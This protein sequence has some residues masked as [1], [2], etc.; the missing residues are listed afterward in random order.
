MITDDIETQEK[1]TELLNFLADY[2]P[3]YSTG[4]DGSKPCIA[5]KNAT[6]KELR[7]FLEDEFTAV[8]DA[9]HDH[10]W[11]YADQNE[12]ETLKQNVWQL[13]HNELYVFSVFLEERWIGTMLLNEPLTRTDVRR[14][15]KNFLKAD[16]NWGRQAKKVGAEARIVYWDETK[17]RTEAFTPNEYGFT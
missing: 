2:H 7:I 1:L 5:L 16:K 4:P 11:V 3:K 10:Y 14:Q 17:N 8:Y 6:G 12:F 9:W 15:I 13:L